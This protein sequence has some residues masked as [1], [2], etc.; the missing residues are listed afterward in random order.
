MVQFAP[1]YYYYYYCYCYCYYYYYYYHPA[2]HSNSLAMMQDYMKLMVAVV[3][4]A[5]MVVLCGNVATIP[6]AVWGFGRSPSGSKEHK[7]SPQAPQE[8]SRRVAPVIQKLGRE[9]RIPL[10]L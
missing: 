10:H 4:V 3:L 7:F 5:D 6:A 8:T 1:V 2:Y 9:S